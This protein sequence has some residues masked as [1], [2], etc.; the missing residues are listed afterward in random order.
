MLLPEALLFPGKII[1]RWILST[2]FISYKYDHN[3]RMREKMDEIQSLAFQLKS[4]MAGGLPGL[5]AQLIMSPVNRK[6]RYDGKLRKETSKKAGVLVLLYPCDKGKI[7]L[8]LIQRPEYDGAHGG[9][10]SFPGGKREKRDKSI[11][12]T[13]LREANEEIGVRPSEVHILGLM[14]ELYVWASNATVAPVLAWAEK[15]P[16]F[17]PDKS[18]VREILEVDIILLMDRRN[19]KSKMLR[20]KNGLAV[21]A[22]YYD[23]GG[24]MIWGATA[25]ILSELVELLKSTKPDRYDH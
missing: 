25:M 14:T 12:E 22:P 4:E 20:L 16:V 8:P 7:C 10:V 23:I 11:V 9:Q 6:Y 3:V 19:I 21:E 24:K 2:G 13:A 1:L 5:E 15:R 17:I 18:E